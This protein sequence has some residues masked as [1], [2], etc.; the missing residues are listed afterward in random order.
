MKR[1]LVLLALLLAGCSDGAAPL[2]PSGDVPAKITLAWVS[3]TASQAVAW[4]AYEG[5]YFQQNGLD[6]TLQYIE[7]SPVAA[8]ALVNGGVQFVQMAGPAV[9]AANLGGAHQVM[10]M[11]FVNEPLFI[12]VAN[13][14]ITRP[15]ELRGKTVAVTR[16]GSSDDFMLR[17]ALTN[18]GLQPDVDVKI[19]SVPATQGRVASF[20]QGLVQG[21][22]AGVTEELPLTRAGGHVLIRTADLGLPYQA[23]GLA[24]TRDY[25]QAHPDITS[26]VVKAM[27]QGVH[28]YKTDKPFA[29]KMLS[30]YIKLDDPAALDANYKAYVDVFPRAPAPTLEGMQQVAKELA[31]GGQSAPAAGVAAMVDPSFVRQLEDSG[32]I[33]QLYGG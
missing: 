13:P 14:D 27:T 10:L 32:F 20:T 21:V 25:V 26:R 22:M 3:A 4:L 5:G 23:A 15:E 7:T 24:S 19:T 2:A 31:A 17:Q 16:V 6:V 11:G 9:V 33:R 29:E 30:K 18:W 12:L 8:A 1:G 28:R